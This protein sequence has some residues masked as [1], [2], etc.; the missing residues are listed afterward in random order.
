MGIKYSKT[1]RVAAGVALSSMLLAASAHAALTISTEATQNVSCSGGVCAA[2]AADA[3]LNVTDLTNMLT[4][5]ALTIQSGSLAQDIVVNAPFSWTSANALTLDSYH[6]ITVNQPVSDAGPAALTITTNDG[7]TGGTLFFG[8]KGSI[9]FLSTANALT[10]NEQI[11]K[12]EANLKNLAFDIARK[13]AGSF[14]LAN[15]YDARADGLYLLS[16][17]TTTLRG[18]FTG[19]GNTISKLTIADGGASENVGLFA[20]LD[21]KAHVSSVRLKGEVVRGPGNGSLV[22]G[23]VGTNNGL[24]DNVSIDG[25]AAG[26]VA[27][28]GLLAGINNGG[29]FRSSTSGAVHGN[30]AG[31]LVG[32]GGGTIYSSQSSTKVSGFAAAGGLEAASGGYYVANISLSSASGDVTAFGP[33]GGLVGVSANI[34]TSFA[35]GNVTC[36]NKQ[37]RYMIAGGLIGEAISQYPTTVSDSYATGTVKTADA[38]NTDDAGG[39]VGYASVALATSYSTGRLSKSETAIVGGSVGVINRKQGGKAIDIY[40]DRG[41]AHTH[42][43]VGD[44]PKK[45]VMGLTDAE[46]KSDLPAGFDPN[47]WAEDPNINNGYPYLIANP[48]VK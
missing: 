23:L 47:V 7:G 38:D 33:A 6:A 44:G 13:P 37:Q 14:A 41:T 30:Y 9:G 27:Y 18:T 35:T 8:A 39:L 1:A 25:L 12:L 43:G 46:L 26:S 21:T 17:I 29:I 31:G 24:I 11:Y 36:R 19:L 20:V 10:I 48:P 22:G 16:P 28:V 2:T 32:E 4:S 40:W 5:S 34:D 15:A 42:K 3:V 45:G